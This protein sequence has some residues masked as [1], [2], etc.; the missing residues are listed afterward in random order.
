MIES[1]VEIATP[2][3]TMDA[4]VTHPEE[5]GP[6]PAVVVFMDIWGLREELFDIARKVAVVGYHC[7][8]PNFYYRQGRVRFEFRDDN[9]RMKSRS[10]LPRTAR[11]ECAP[12]Q[13]LPTRWRST[14]SARCWVSCASQ[15]VKRGPRERS[16]IAWAAAM[17]S[18]RRRAYPDEFRASRACTARSW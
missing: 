1:M 18:R 2:A 5:G 12:A 6:F 14:T 15:P 13:V 8:V 16:A 7:M 4:F 3:G 17:R 10:A 9:G 11:S